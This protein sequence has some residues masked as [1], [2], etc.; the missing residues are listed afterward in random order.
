MKQHLAE[1]RIRVLVNSYFDW[2]NWTRRLLARER[3]L[4]AF[5]HA[6]GTPVQS[7]SYV[8]FY[9]LTELQVSEVYS[10]LFFQ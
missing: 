9:M 1:K 8:Y 7:Y 5:L 2:K 4:V 3:Y 10:Y 6:H